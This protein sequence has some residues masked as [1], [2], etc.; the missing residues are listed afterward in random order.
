MA[1]A[2]VALVAMASIE[3]N[4]PRKPF[5]SPNRASKAGMAVSS[6]ALSGTAS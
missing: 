3:T 5:C 1:V 2:I 4:T 6:L